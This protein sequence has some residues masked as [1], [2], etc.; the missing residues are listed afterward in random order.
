MN[1]SSSRAPA[2]S[3]PL[4]LSS[5]AIFVAFSL[6]AFLK[7][8]MAASKRLNARG[9]GEALLLSGFAPRA[10]SKSVDAGIRYR[11]FERPR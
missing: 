1:T 3:S 2:S 8:F 10:D 11:Q 7:S 4:H 5:P 6:W 9:P